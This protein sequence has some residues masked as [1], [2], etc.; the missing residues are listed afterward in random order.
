MPGS[1]TLIKCCPVRVAARD[2]QKPVP[3]PLHGPHPSGSQQLGAAPL[4]LRNPLT[5]NTNQENCQ[6]RC[7]SPIL[8][9]EQPGPREVLNLPKD[10]HLVT[11]VAGI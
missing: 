5:P 8:E 6:S 2:L 4:P 1:R 3:S 10:V 7:L 11:T 9:I